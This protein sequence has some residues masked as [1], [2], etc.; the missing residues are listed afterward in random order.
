MDNSSDR[1]R[2]QFYAQ[3]CQATEEDEFLNLLHVGG[4]EANASMLLP[5]LQ[6]AIAFYFFIRDIEFIGINEM[7]SMINVKNVINVDF[8]K[9]F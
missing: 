3:D 4:R 6:Q 2:P 8:L 1:R 5:H 7:S 9:E